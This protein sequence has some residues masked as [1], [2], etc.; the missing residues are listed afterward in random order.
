MA[1]SF[2]GLFYPRLC[3]ACGQN[4]PPGSEPVCIS[5][6]YKLPRTSH[7]QFPENEFTE[8]F[9]GRVDIQAAA[10]CF[11]FVKT[12]RVQRL[13]HH[14][15]YERKR[16]IGT[17]FGREYGAVLRAVPG[18]KNVDLIVPVPL[19]WRKKRIRGYNQAAAFAEGLSWSMCC[20]WEEALERVVHTDT[21]TKKSRLDR[22]MNVAQAFQLKSPGQLE[23]KHILLVDDVVTTGA[24]LEVCTAELLKEAGCTVSLAAIA[25]AV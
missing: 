12:G 7:H 8:R 15:K 22:L 17:Y 11:Q 6:H 20:P 14:L 9:W 23:G 21:Q 3:Y 13:L 2:A 25:I 1:E 18:F 24:T 16:E 5:C 19:H 10:A 4:L